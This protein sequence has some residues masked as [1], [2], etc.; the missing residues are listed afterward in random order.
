METD[1]RVSSAI[2]IK[3]IMVRYMA[4]NRFRIK[5]STAFLRHKN[6]EV[7]RPCYTMLGD[8]NMNGKRWPL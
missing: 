3:A 2:S 6:D 5:V 8:K 4:S 7:V 1:R